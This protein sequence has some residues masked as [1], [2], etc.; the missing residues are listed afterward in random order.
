MLLP[1]P[2][3]ALLLL[4][5]PALPAQKIDYP[6]VP[7]PVSVE[8][9]PAVEA[10]VAPAPAPPSHWDTPGA[11]GLDP[12]V[13]EVF[14]E[15]EAE[16][17]RGPE[18]RRRYLER[19]RGFGLDAPREAALYALKSLQVEMV[20]LGAALLEFVGE[21]DDATELVSTAAGIGS[22]ATA[23]T[24]L[25]VAL[26]LNGGWLPAR[27]V[28]L[29]DHPERGVRA[30]VEARLGRLADDSFQAP[31]LQALRFGRDHDSRL[32]AAR[33][34][35]TYRAVPDVRRA[36]LETLRDPSVP[37][38]FEAADSLAGEADDPSRALLRQDLLAS[39]P[40]IT[41]AYLAYA[42][43]RQMEI[44]GSLLVDAAL[45]AK[46]R[47]SLSEPDLFL[48]GVCAACLAEYLFRS[49]DL[50]TLRPSEGAILHAL[51]KAVGGMSF[52]P[53]YSRFSEIG[54]LSLSRVTGE[55]FRHLKRDAWLRWYAE[56]YLE[57]QPVRGLLLVTE[58]DL[59]RLRVSWRR[60]GGEARCL[61]G[62]LAADP[63]AVTR[64]LG[65]GGLTRLLERIEAAR[66][67]EA[68]VLPGTYG[69]AGAA[70]AARIEI[71][72]GAQRKPLTFRGDSA[73][74]WLPSLL[75]DLDIFFAELAWEALLPVDGRQDAVVA[76]LEAWDVAD[77]EGRRRFDLA[78]TA[79]RILALD[80]AT[81]LAWCRRLA[82]DPAYAELTDLAL[83]RAFLSEVPHRS[84][85][86][87]LARELLDAGLRRPDAALAAELVDRL[88]ELSEPLRT[89]L[90]LRGLLALGPEVAAERLGDPRL[91]V[92]V[93]AAR[94]LGSAG[95]AGKD[96]LLAALGDANALVVQMAA[97]SLGQLG[98]PEV[99]PQLLALTRPELSRGVRSEALW[100]LGQIADPDCLATVAACCGADQDPAI[101]LAAIQALGRMS[102][103]GVDSAFA[104]LFPA[105]AGGSLE[106]AY[107]RALT[108]RGAGVARSILR[109]WFLAAD[110][111]VAARGAIL[112]GRLG[113]PEAAERLILLLPD[114]PHDQE[115]LAALV[116]VTGVDRRSTPDPAGVLA[117]WWGENGRLGAAYWLERAAANAGF[118]LPEEF[119]RAEQVAPSEAVAALV[120]VLEGG[121]ASLRP[122]V[123]YFLTRLTG[124]DGPAFR[125]DT[126]QETVQAAARAWREW[127]PAPGAR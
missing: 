71:V 28:R 4:F 54:E 87:D 116:A 41:Q 106:L 51:V 26:R 120:A 23:T 38:A 8:A 68:L 95:G 112:A 70:D 22:V 108:S 21:P 36:L 82:A 103:T 25:E 115:L 69:P 73:A 81:L 61:S 98:D 66:L 58:A 89:D 76:R 90:L 123:G 97:R 91:P 2:V 3:L 12:R 101:R 85:D 67:L 83:A 57:F 94:A 53:Q 99:L 80:D 93:A 122:L 65:R 96:A 79:E 118:E 45:L 104:E 72:A 125:S 7:K 24:C 74:A 92:R 55:D 16:Q 110:P 20:E 5:A 34:L 43:L 17:D 37:V 42:L 9:P 113:D 77:A 117:A 32:R 60:G 88:A 121:P 86:P 48:S 105:F 59:P 50:E 27:A 49:T 56:H 64:W 109:P 100:A 107:E 75:D 13:V 78:L 39:E 47:G 111:V 62:P 30:A 35:R 10:P 6:K 102:G 46:L 84:A 19:L 33:L 119:D 52:Y 127:K 15:F 1:A 44:S 124:L 114:T 40:G 18:A 63:S 29:L 31:L 11:A 14:R 126:P